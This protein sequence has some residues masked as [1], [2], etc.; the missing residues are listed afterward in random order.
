MATKA[1]TLHGSRAMPVPVA[2]RSGRLSEALR[3]LF[4]TAR[5]DAQERRD[6]RG[7]KERVDVGRETGARC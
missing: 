4:A 1:G 3:A 5:A 7:W 2:S 6:M